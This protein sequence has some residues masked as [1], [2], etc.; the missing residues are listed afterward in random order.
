MSVHPS[1]GSER[2]DRHGDGILEES[3]AA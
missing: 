1:R 2:M 3:L